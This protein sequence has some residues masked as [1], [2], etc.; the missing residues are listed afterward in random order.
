MPDP[1]CSLPPDSTTSLNI[2]RTGRA[3]NLRQALW[4][5]K[6]P[7]QTGIVEGFQKTDVNERVQIGSAL[8]CSLFCDFFDETFVNQFLQRRIVIKI[9][10]GS[11]RILTGRESDPYSFGIYERH[12]GTIFYEVVMTSG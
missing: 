9:T 1:Y 2:N 6:N 5:V 12:K 8:I 4:F 3:V 10:D 7:N 11:V